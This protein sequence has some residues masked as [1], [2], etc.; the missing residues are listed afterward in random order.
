MSA[1]ETR[2]SY[3][4]QS[5]FCPFFSFAI[6]LYLFSFGEEETERKGERVN[7]K[8]GTKH[9]M[10][11]RIFNM[12]TDTPNKINKQHIIEVYSFFHNTFH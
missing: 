6:L 7:E 8:R 4:S 5:Y 1:V 10:Y 2:F 12:R 11:N 3:R 9:K